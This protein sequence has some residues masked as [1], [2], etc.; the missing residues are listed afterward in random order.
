MKRKTLDERARELAHRLSRHMYPNE[1]ISRRGDIAL[2]QATAYEVG[3]MDGYI[4]G[5]NA[6][7]RR[8][9]K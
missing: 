2:K 3:C 7:R 6:E 5:A 1:S 8:M 9:R 4:A